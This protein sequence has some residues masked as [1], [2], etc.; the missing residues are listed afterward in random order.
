MAKRS[1]PRAIN[2][3]AAKAYSEAFAADADDADAEPEASETAEAASPWAAGAA[4]NPA[5]AETQGAASG[6]SATGRRA[7]ALKVIKRASL[8]SGAA[9]LIPFPL[10]DLAG[11]GAIQI[12]ML[13]RVSRI[14]DVPFSENLGRA[15]LASFAGSAI[16]TTSAIGGA[17]LMKS[18]PVIGTVVSMVAMPALS[19]GATYAVGLAFIQHFSSGGTLDDFDPQDYRDEVKA[20]TSSETT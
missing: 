10:V 4:I 12:D 1:L 5:D 8:L 2:P 15:L 13:R 9:G 17:S 7:G 20:G 18:V 11:V 19:A 6:E 3:A 14:Y 16:P